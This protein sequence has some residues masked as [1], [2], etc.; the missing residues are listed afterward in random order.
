MMPDAGSD[1]PDASTG[2]DAHETGAAPATVILN[3]LSP[4]IADNHELVELLVTSPGTVKDIELR[5]DYSGTGKLLAKLPDVEVGHNDLIVIHLHP[6]DSVIEETASRAECTDP[7]CYGQA[8]DFVGEAAGSADFGYSYRVAV[9]KAANGDVL[10]A[11]PFMRHMDFA[12]KPAAY[13]TD[14]PMIISDDL[15][16]EVCTDPC[17][18]D[19]LDNMYAASVDWSDA[20]N[21]VDGNSVQRKSG[22]VNDRKISD[23]NDTVVAPTLGDYNK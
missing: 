20:G 22:G 6:V 18:Y 1:T 14:L 10:D 4:N 7:A 5:Q 8:W 15:W 12:Q 19:H 2:P 3:E 23:W 11:V 13:A 21:A 17:D 9:L 16:N